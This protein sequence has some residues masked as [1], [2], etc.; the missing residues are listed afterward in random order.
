LLY[1]NRER[2]IIF[3]DCDD[4]LRDK[5]A[6]DLLKS[7]LDSYE[8]RWVSWYIERDTDLPTTFKFK[9][10]I[11]FVTNIPIPKIDSAVRSR[12]FKVDIHMTKPQC[13]QWIRKALPDVL[14]DVDMQHKED[15]L[16]L[17]EENMH[18]T[19]DVNFRSLMNLTTIRTSP[20]RNWK[21]LGVYSL[22]VKD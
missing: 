5:S 19:N 13:I 18:V 4:I 21:K 20:V 22:M 6:I 12:A 11:V 10:K 8:D 1:E 15:A 3:D 2:T 7:A 17:L 9:G 14:P 16:N